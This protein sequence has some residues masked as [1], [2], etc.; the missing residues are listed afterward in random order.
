[1]AFTGGRGPRDLAL[2]TE[3]LGESYRI[4]EER[5]KRWACRAPIHPA[6]D[7]ITAMRAGRPF[8]AAEVARVD[9]QLPWGSFKAIGFPYEPSSV[10][11]AQLNLQY[12]VAVMLLD[13][14][15]FVRQ[16]DEARLARPDILDV[17]SRITVTHDPALDD[18][19]LG[20]K[21][22]D[23]I[24][25]ITLTDGQVLLHR[26]GAGLL[27]A[28]DEVSTQAVADKFA[29]ISANAIGPGTQAAIAERCA[30]LEEIADVRELIELLRVSSRQAAP[31]SG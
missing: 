4:R 28:R 2:L 18:P 11:T 19:A 9:V 7:A 16:F 10:A 22:R 1:M 29:V 17:I 23:T 12:C 14:E 26:S 24:V 20:P 27:L 8:S 3:G 13:G 21:P 15:V 25:T 6:L 5:F 30:R 31:A